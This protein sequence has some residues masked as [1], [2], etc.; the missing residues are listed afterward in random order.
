MECGPFGD[1]TFLIKHIR[2]G[3]VLAPT[4]G[5]LTVPVINSDAIDSN[6]NSNTIVADSPIA[7]EHHID[8]ISISDGSD[9]EG[10][11]IVAVVTLAAAI[12]VTARAHIVWLR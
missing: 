11:L 12:I 4:V 9:Y 7:I 3:P 5:Q 10:C 8:A 2:D 6:M 1:P